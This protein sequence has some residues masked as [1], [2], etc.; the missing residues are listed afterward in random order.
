MVKGDKKKVG[1][2]QI[3]LEIHPLLD[4]VKK[5]KWGGIRR[6]REVFQ[7]AQA[8]LRRWH[9]LRHEWRVGASHAEFWKIMS[10]RGGRKA[11]VLKQEHV[12]YIQGLNKGAS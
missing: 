6:T 3:N 10:S 9:E 2:R 7:P 4:A 11:K 8:S 12:Q 1:G 5:I